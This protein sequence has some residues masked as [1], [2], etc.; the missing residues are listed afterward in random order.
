MAAPA[1]PGCRQRCS[2]SRLS[3][4]P[5][6]LPPA[7]SA[8]SGTKGG[9]SGSG[10]GAPSADPTQPGGGHTTLW[11]QDYS[12]QRRAARWSNR[13]CQGRRFGG[14]LMSLA[15]GSAQCTHTATCEHCF[16][17]FPPSAVN[18]LLRPP[19]ARPQHYFCR[20][21]RSSAGR[22][23]LGWG[24]RGA[25]A[26]YKLR[27]GAQEVSRITL[28]SVLQQFEEARPSPRGTE[29]LI[30]FLLSFSVTHPPLF[31]SLR[32]SRCHRVYPL[33]RKPARARAR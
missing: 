29:R 26:E 20:E 16:S 32:R 24:G 21:I 2:C 31:A 5:A 25:I 12:G 19:H 1:S 30:S 28:L 4:T 8:V 23:I 27:L 10:G 6:M 7:G 22:S 33:A 11:H 9:G 13:W 15:A 14:I 3:W 17:L 18:G